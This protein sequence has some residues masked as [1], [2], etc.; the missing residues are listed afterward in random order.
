MVR[1]ETA[2]YQIKLDIKVICPSE[3][4]SHDYLMAETKVSKNNLMSIEFE[5]W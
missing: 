3:S 5:K 2:S 4:L 1:S